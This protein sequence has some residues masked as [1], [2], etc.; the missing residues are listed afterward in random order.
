MYIPDFFPVSSA[1]QLKQ[2]CN[3]RVILWLQ[4]I[5]ILPDSLTAYNAL[6]DLAFRAADNGQTVTS[7]AI[8]ARIKVTSEE[9]GQ[10][11]YLRGKFSEFMHK[12]A[13]LGEKLGVWL[14]AY[15]H[16]QNRCS[17]NN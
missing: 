8:N 11:K 15:A 17:G 13:Y 1:R 4:N 9:R 3:N 14:A 5:L 16:V 2:L 7:Q 6:P 10:R 12:G